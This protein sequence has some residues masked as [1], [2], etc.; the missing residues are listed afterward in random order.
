[1]S[2]K[3]LIKCSFCGK[4]KKD[5]FMMIG[6]LNGHICDQCVSQAQK[7]V[8]EEYKLRSDNKKIQLVKPTE[9]KKLLDEYMI[10]QDEAKK[11]MSVAVYNHYKRILQ[12]TNKK[13]ANA[14]EPAD[15]VEIEKS[16]IVLVGE[17]GTGKTLIAQTIARI[18]N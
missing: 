11:V 5:V 16:N 14:N 4:D 18:L 10:D 3:E 12:K 15:D 17:T 13:E 6:G 8:E 7:I 1:M 2:E 9:I